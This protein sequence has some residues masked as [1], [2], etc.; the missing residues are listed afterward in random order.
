MVKKIG[1]VCSGG[2]APGMNACI[3]AITRMAEAS[4]VQIFGIR[5]GFQGLIDGDMLE[6]NLKQVENIISQGGTILKTSRCEEFMTEN[7]FKKAVNFIKVND[8]D[9]IIVLGGDGSLT[10]AGRLSDAGINVIGIPCTID[11]DLNYTDFTIG[12]DTA[13][14]TVTELLQNVR[15]TSASHNRV[16]VIEVMG[17][18]SGEIASYSGTASGAEVILVPEVK[19]SDKE[20]MAK[21]KNSTSRGEKCV[22]VV[23]AEGVASAESVA[24]KIKKQTGFDVKSM[25]LSYVQRGGA[26]STADRILATRMGAYVLSEAINKN[27]GVAV[28]VT[29]KEIK[30][31]PL[32]KIHNAPAKFD[33]TLLKLND[34]LSI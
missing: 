26:P 8:F 9:C 34:I 32:N 16:C 5:G 27:F 25:N 15:D 28:G 4:G 29:G 31:F 3:R 14:N 2:D 10:G 17:R 20:L 1:V 22:L 7:G 30:S 18:H 19:V 6:L 24:K 13:I 21:V 11:N 33:K 23:V 12:F